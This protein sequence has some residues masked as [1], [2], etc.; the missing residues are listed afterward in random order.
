MT[1]QIQP[2]LV[3]F[4]RSDAFSSLVLKRLACSTHKT[5]L[6]VTQLPLSPVIILQPTVDI[7]E[8]SSPSSMLR[9]Y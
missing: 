3:C 6:S 5:Y 8:M 2:A 7:S 4:T 9:G 1:I